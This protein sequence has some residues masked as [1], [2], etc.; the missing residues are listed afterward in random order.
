M[1]N[2][3]NAQE[4]GRVLR[5]IGAAAHFDDRSY[6]LEDIAM[7]APFVQLYFTPINSL[8]PFAMQSKNTFLS[9]KNSKLL[10]VLILVLIN[11]QHSR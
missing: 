2:I 4:K 5:N 10:H 3:Y 8:Q 9:G 1:K 7:E 6:N 11:S